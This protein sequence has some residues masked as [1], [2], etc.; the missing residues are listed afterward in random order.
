MPYDMAHRS[1]FG[2]LAFEVDSQAFVLLNEQHNATDSGG[3]SRSTQPEHLEHGS[4]ST[5]L[6]YLVFCFVL[7]SDVESLH[8]L[9]EDIKVLPDYK[10]DLDVIYDFENCLHESVLEN[11]GYKQIFEA[12]IE[13]DLLMKYNVIS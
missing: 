11:D 13:N 10:I 4:N 5:L 2:N 3:K 6:M 8:Y 1:I 9:L 7:T 12:Y